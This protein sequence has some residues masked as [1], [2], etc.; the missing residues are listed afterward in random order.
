MHQCGG[1]GSE[2]SWGERFNLTR[3]DKHSRTGAWL[4]SVRLMKCS[5]G[6]LLPGVDPLSAD[7][8]EIIDPTLMGGG[9]V[10]LFIGNLPAL[11]GCA[12]TLYEL[13]S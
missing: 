13:I 7:D 12:W 5:P 6:S 3:P 4:L 2:E 9:L 1:P 11:R 10:L 8:Y